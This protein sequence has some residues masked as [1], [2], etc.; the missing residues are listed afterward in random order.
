MSARIAVLASG[1]GSNLQ[2]LLDDPQVGA[3]VKLVLSDRKDAKALQR[4]RDVGVKA[5]FLDPKPHRDRQSYDEAVLEVLKQEGI[6]YVALAGFMR[7]LSPV[8]VRAYEGRMLNIH[9]SL[10]PA[11]PGGNAIGDALAY[12]AKVTGVTIHFVDE[13]VDHGPIVMQESLP[14]LRGDDEWTL[15]A[16]IHELEHR[17]YRRAVLAMVEARL[18]VRGRTVH[19]LSEDER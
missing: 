2:A 14:I 1:V 7:I 17:L 16:R 18:E 3:L 9:P 13:Q 8:L 15:A 19:L 10:L 5:V 11:F 4:A 12:G 6:E